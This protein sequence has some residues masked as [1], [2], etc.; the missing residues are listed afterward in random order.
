MSDYKNGLI[1]GLFLG[2]VITIA[3]AYILRHFFG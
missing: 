1:S 3:A 2:I